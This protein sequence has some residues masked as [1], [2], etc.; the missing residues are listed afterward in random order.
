MLDSAVQLRIGLQKLVG[1]C[2]TSVFIS[3]EVAKISELCD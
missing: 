3:Y 1:E 2:D